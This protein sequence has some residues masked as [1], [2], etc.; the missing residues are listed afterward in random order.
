MGDIADGILD[1]DFDEET[2]EY[3]GPG[4]GFPRSLAREQREKQQMYANYNTKNT[5]PTTGPNAVNGVFKFLKGQKLEQEEIDNIIIKY[6]NEEIGI[7][8][9]VENIKEE[10]CNQIQKDFG[11]FVKWFKKTYK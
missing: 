3:I 10:T 7:S 2:G 6:N 4:M 9:E 8:K 1:G 11:K 5:T